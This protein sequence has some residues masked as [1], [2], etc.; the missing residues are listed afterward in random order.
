MDIV[1]SLDPAAY[2]E[3]VKNYPYSNPQRLFLTGKHVYKIKAC[4]SVVRFFHLERKFYCNQ[5]L[6]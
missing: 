6:N 4:K 3:K 5:E 1:K 2:P